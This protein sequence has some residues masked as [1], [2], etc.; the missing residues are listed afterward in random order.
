MRKFTFTLV[1]TLCWMGINAA[2][3]MD[4]LVT[5]TTF[6]FSDLSN[7]NWQ[8]LQ[9]KSMVEIVPETPKSGVDLYILADQE[10]APNVYAWDASGSALNG[11]WPGSRLSTTANVARIGDEGN[12]A[13]FYKVHFDND[14][15]SFIVNYTG[16]ADKTNNISVEGPGCY[17]FKYVSYKGYTDDR[18]SKITKYTLLPINI[19]YEG[20]T[21]Y[22]SNFIYVRS[23]NGDFTPTVYKW[24]AYYQGPWDQSWAHTEMKNVSINN[25]NNWYKSEFGD[26]NSSQG[27]LILSNHGDDNTKTCD[28]TWLNGG[29]DFFFNYYPYGTADK[30]EPVVMMNGR[31]NYFKELSFN[32]GQTVEGDGVKVTFIDR[33]TLELAQFAKDGFTLTLSDPN[34]I[35]LDE[36]FVDNQLRLNLGATISMCQ[37]DGHDINM[38]SFH[39]QSLSKPLDVEVLLQCGEFNLPA[40]QAIDAWG[41]NY[42][43]LG[44]FDQ[45]CVIN[46][47]ELSYT[48]TNRNYGID[49]QYLAIDDIYMRDGT[50]ASGLADAYGT[51]RGFK[52]TV[53]TPMVVV[54]YSGDDGNYSGEGV[55]YC[56]SIESSKT[57]T[58]PEPTADQV[59][60]GQVLSSAKKFTNYD[61]I[62]IRLDP[63]MKAVWD[64]MPKAD[65]LGHVIE[66]G[67]IKGDFCDFI[68][69]NNRLAVAYLNPTIMADQLPKLTSEVVETELNEYYLLNFVKQDHVFVIPPKRNEVCNVNY[70]IPSGD[71]NVV[72]NVKYDFTDNTGET[73]ELKSKVRIYSYTGTNTDEFMN[74]IRLK[75]TFEMCRDGISAIVKD[76][77][78]QMIDHHGEQF[79]KWDELYDN[80]EDKHYFSPVD[81]YE[82]YYDPSGPRRYP[83]DNI[84][85][86]LP[87]LDYDVVEYFGVYPHYRLAINPALAAKRGTSFT[88]VSEIMGG[89]KNVVAV[90]YYNLA[91]QK[92]S[93]AFDGFNVMVIRYSDGTTSSKKMINTIQ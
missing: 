73:Y 89:A 28:I 54:R 72:Y 36:V 8:D 42:G 60:K 81:T 31:T 20:T 62:A 52:W 93:T 5:E 37:H 65:Y 43:D 82:S 33:N 79:Y 86:L 9:N 16:D 49:N 53:T 88:G 18:Q 51:F 26:G 75:A 50:I 34:G 91:G 3:N 17:F 55:I 21:V 24:T 92:S 87:I 56:R 40:K 22:S 15:F 90:E 6:K 58:F 77:V 61:W 13:T 27:G 76:A 32:P 29:G 57:Y 2:I 70:V 1:M 7:V 71:D 63:E 44:G 45:I 59:A 39:G 84:G 48:F 83:S 80:I 4:G 66:P 30:I 10:A 19:Y 67:S 41:N 85:Y 25:E 38:L 78:V 69:N 74:M 47:P 11:G 14:Q 35:V 64:D 46:G 12:Q 68:M 23:I